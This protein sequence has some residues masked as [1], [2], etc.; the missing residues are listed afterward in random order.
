MKSESIK[1]S[2]VI[3]STPKVIFKAWLSGSEHSAMT[4]S[5]AK[6]TARVGGA[7]TAWDGYISGRRKKGTK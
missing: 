4:G 6:S 3:P 7:F 5:A 1:V 2:A